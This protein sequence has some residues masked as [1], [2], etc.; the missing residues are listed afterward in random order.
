MTGFLIDALVLAGA[1]AA[2][3]MVLL[4]VVVFAAVTLY[5]IEL[6]QGQR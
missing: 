4:A 5:L 2:L 3:G 1:M 6:W